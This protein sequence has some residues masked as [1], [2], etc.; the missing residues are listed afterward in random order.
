MQREIE[1]LWTS[2]CR[3]AVDRFFDVT[4]A[5]PAFSESHSKLFSNDSV[6]VSKIDGFVIYESRVPFIN[7]FA[8]E[9]PNLFV[10]SDDSKGKMK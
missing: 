6:T 9:I 3:N 5:R 1:G 2:A 8:S 10:S 7:Y 4:C